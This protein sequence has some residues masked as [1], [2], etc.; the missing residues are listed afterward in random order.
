MFSLILRLHLDK[1]TSSSETGTSRKEASTEQGWPADAI[2]KRH[3]RYLDDDDIEAQDGRG[4]GPSHGRTGRRDSSVSMRSGRESR[5]IDP[6]HGI[7]ITYRTV[8]FNIA[9]SQERA[10]FEAH[11]KKKELSDGEL[12]PQIPPYFA[13]LDVS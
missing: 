10:T 7:P 9:N 2:L 8:S 5:E 3:I 13:I 4:P 11:K 12:E 1:M 6:R